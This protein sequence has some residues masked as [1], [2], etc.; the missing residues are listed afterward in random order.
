M[1]PDSTAAGGEGAEP[2]DP[3]AQPQDPKAGEGAKPQDTG[4]GEGNTVNRHQYERDI[5]NRDKT[6]GE[7]R[8]EVERLRGEGG[9]AADAMKAVEELKAQLEDERTNSALSAA[10]CVNAKAAK[11]LLGDYEGDV[12]KLKEAC[13]YLFGHAGAAVSTGGEPAGSS[14]ADRRAKARAA[15]GLKD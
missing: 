13:P 2:Q 1:D 11:A 10:G 5:A 3:Q 14:P 8:A 15:A 9:K 4:S 7:L 12:A 6:I